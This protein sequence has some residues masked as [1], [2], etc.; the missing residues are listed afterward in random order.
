MKKEEKGGVVSEMET[1]SP[2]SYRGKCSSHFGPAS[3][4]HEPTKMAVSLA[5]S[6]LHLY[7]K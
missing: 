7:D 6:C 5:D 2:W 3:T 4:Y 1:A